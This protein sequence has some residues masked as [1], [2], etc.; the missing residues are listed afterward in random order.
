[1]A[2]VLADRVKETSLTTG[3]GTITLAGAV[4]GYQ[5]FSVIGNGNTTYYVI[6]GQNSAEWEVGIGTYTAAGTTLSRSTVLASSNSGS[7]VNFS[8]GAKDVFVSYPA[9][10][11]VNLDASGNLVTGATSA[12]SFA[13]SGSTVPANGLYLPSANTLGLATNSTLGLTLDSSQYLGNTVLG[14]GTGRVP[15]EQYYRLNTTVVGANA[16][17]AQAVLGVGVTLAGS[18][19]Y[20]F[21]GL[22]VMS[23]SAGTT[24]YTMSTLFGGTATLNN[25][26]YLILR[27]YDTAAFL[28]TNNAPAAMAYAQVATAVTTMTGSTTASTY[29]ILSLRGTVSVNAGGTFIPQYSLSAAPG[30]AFTTQIGSYFKIS[31]LSASGANT[32]I[33]TWA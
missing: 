15:A 26:G 13:P 4:L 5:S 14:M 33:G 2:L 23:K 28:G 30:G 29:H 27:Y 31:P 7:L 17:G 18:T 6:A 8:A 3:T 21:E 22:Y 19:V 16:T 1:M 9:G 25:I 12:P 32:N 10:K 11:S 20:Q 24:S